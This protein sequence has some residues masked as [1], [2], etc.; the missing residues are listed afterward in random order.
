[1][2]QKKM[3]NRPSTP[4]P[5]KCLASGWCG[6]AK[7]HPRSGEGWRGI[8]SSCIS[9][10]SLV[11]RRLPNP[12]LILGS[13]ANANHY[14]GYGVTKYPF[15]QYACW[16]QDLCFSARCLIRRCWITS[17]WRLCLR[18]V[19]GTLPREKLH[20]FSSEHTQTACH[21]GGLHEVCSSPSSLPL[22]SP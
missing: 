4:S 7:L 9:I 18:R 5:L 8:M 14:T 22:L 16:D 15:Q 21:L 19:H 3:M 20:Q 13:Y 1:M 11:P 2:Y 10:F 12:L 6:D 17:T